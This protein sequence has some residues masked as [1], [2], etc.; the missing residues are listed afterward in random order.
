MASLTLQVPDCVW[1]RAL[2]S[3]AVTVDGYDVRFEASAF[4]QRTSRRLRGEVE[5]RYAGAEQV[6]TDYIVRVA[7]GTEKELAALPVFV[8]RGMVQR[9]FVMR[10]GDTPGALKGRA[11]GQGRVL[12]ATSVYLRGLLADHHGIERSDVSWVAAEPLGSDGAIGGEWRYLR[13]RG[14]FKAADLIARLS[15]GELDAVIYPGGA[16]GHWFNWIA[17]G[18]ASRTPDP[19]GDLEQMVARSSDLWFPVGDLDSHVAWF[20][21]ERIYPAYH[22]LAVRHRVA[23]ENPGLP[24]ALVEAFNRAAKLAPGYMTPEERRLYEREI[25][26][27]GIDPN[28]CGLNALHA[29]TVEKC[30]DYLEADGVL[31]RRPTISEIFPLLT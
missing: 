15:A 23:R 21:R 11:I 14:G 26:I 2:F 30:V 7:R 24:A 5:E 20:N 28:E 19:Y 9:K 18:G 31:G 6:L 12:G 25:E 4:D 17:E 1:T 22:C 16:G 10:R 29:R 3:G 27:L 13:E 8:T